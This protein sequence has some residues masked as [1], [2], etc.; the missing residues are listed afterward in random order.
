MKA[1]SALRTIAERQGGEFGDVDGEIDI[2]EGAHLA[3]ANGDVDGLVTDALKV[4]VDADDREDEAEID[5]HRLFHGE[6]VE[7]HLID[8]ALETVDGRLGAEN[9][10]ADAEFAGAVGLDG[11]LDRLLGHTGHDEQFFLE[12][13]EVLVKF[14]PHQPNLPVM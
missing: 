5:G 11:A 2:R 7:G 12:I 3:H 14:D 8:L 13:V 1:W 9:E 6:E 4:G 10:L